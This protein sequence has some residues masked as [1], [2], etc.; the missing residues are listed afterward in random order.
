MT[1]YYFS[2]PILSTL[3][4]SVSPG[5]IRVHVSSTL[6]SCRAG[7]ETVSS[8]AHRSHGGEDWNQAFVLR[9]LRQMF[10]SHCFRSPFCCSEFTPIEEPPLW[11]VPLVCWS[12]VCPK[13]LGDCP[14][15][16]M[17]THHLPAHI[18]QEAF[19]FSLAQAVYFGMCRQQRDVCDFTGNYTLTRRNDSTWTQ[20]P[21]PRI[22]LPHYRLPQKPHIQTTWCTVMVR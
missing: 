20:Q 2:P 19:G 16:A 13:M 10:P 21:T 11:S 18:S 1:S 22:L 15:V 4:I 12:C 17:K 3:C 14:A 6:F 5:R 8:S 7:L 9:S